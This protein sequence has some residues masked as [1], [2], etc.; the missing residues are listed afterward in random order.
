MNVVFPLFII[1]F[2]WPELNPLDDSNDE[3]KIVYKF[4]YLPGGLF[5]RLQVTNTPVNIKSLVYYYF[6]ISF[7]MIHSVCFVYVTYFL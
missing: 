4:V 2:L 1:K 7:D 3:K 5:N 6:F